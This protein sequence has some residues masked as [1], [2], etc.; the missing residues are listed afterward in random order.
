M[1]TA[2]TIP[3]SNQTRTIRSGT[4]YIES[5]RGRRLRIFL[6]GELVAE[7]VDHPVIRPSINAM[8]ETYDLAVRQPELASAVSPYT[9]ADVN[10]FLHIA[11]SREDLAMQN[12]M[13]RRLGELTGKCFQRCVGMDAMNT[14][15]S[16]TFEID[17]ASCTSYHERFLGFLRLAQEAN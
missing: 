1:S 7:P 13:Q 9:S 5:L 16:V 2:V 17:A 3:T 11:A 8:A 6:F 14:L 4:E 15:H 10:R 12:K